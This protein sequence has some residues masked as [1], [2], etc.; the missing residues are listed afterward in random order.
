MDEFVAIIQ[1]N[2]RILYTIFILVLPPL[3]VILLG[4]RYSIITIEAT[5]YKNGRTDIVLS[6]TH[7][8]SRK[9]TRSSSTNT[10]TMLVRRSETVFHIKQSGKET[11]ADIKLS[12]FWTSKKIIK[13][14]PRQGLQKISSDSLGC[15]STTNIGV[16]SYRCNGTSEFFKYD[17]S[18]RIWENKQL[19]NPDGYTYKQPKSYLDGLLFINTS[20]ESSPVNF[21]VIYSDFANTTKTITPTGEVGLSDPGEVKLVTDS[22]NKDDKTFFLVNTSSLQALMY[23]DIFDTSPKKI[24]LNKNIQSDRLSFLR[25]ASF[26]ATLTCI[27]GP[28]KEAVETQVHG[29]DLP[30]NKNKSQIIKYR[31]TVDTTPLDTTASSDAVH[32]IDEQ[33]S[34]GLS[35]DKK[36]LINS[37]SETLSV[38]GDVD[39]VAVGSLGAMF[40]R[41]NSIYQI[42]QKDPKRAYLVAEGGDHVTFSRITAKG[43]TYTTSAFVKN[44]RSQ[45]LHTY[46]ITLDEKYIGSKIQDTIVSL[47]SSVSS[48]EKIDYYEDTLFIKLYMDSYESDHETGE[49]IIDPDEYRK[50]RQQ[51]GSELRRLKAQD[52]FKEVLITY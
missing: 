13:L 40:M 1:K 21:E 42:D 33:V 36:L 43:K 4:F 6:E 2:K 20:F 17:R 32:M 41:N 48:V 9:R 38:Y 47:T 27:Y 19:E 34:A 11:I 39:E 25:C 15:S 50:K 18:G 10:K 24:N 52:L 23:K 28:G 22:V 14:K 44:S 8:D 30:E 7:Q 45:S 16:V 5:P 51:I 31:N 49:L 3:L 46:N 29:V 37:G 12:P 26:K 35:S